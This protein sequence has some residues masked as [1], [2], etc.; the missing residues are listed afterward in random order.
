[1]ANWVETTKRAVAGHPVTAR[2]LLAG[3]GA[4]LAALSFMCAMPVWLPAGAAGVNN[5]AFPLIL[6]P[7]FWA[8]A[9]TYACLEENLPRGAAV[10]LGSSVLQAAAVALAM[11]G[12]GA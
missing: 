7:L 2:W 10:I 9:F 8:V 11:S 3:P 1:M 5:I 12:G 6:A 4:V